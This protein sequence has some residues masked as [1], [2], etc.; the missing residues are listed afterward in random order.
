MKRR[1][2]VQNNFRKRKRTQCSSQ[3]KGDGRQEER[4]SLKLVHLK[5]AHAGDQN[6]CAQKDRDTGHKKKGN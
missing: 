4:T 2:I 3:Y 6:V 1:S 5:K